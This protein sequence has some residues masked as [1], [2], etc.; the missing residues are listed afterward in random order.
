MCT[1]SSDNHARALDVLVA[2][3]HTKDASNAAK[4]SLLEIQSGAI[5]MAASAG[6]GQRAKLYKYICAV[7]ANATCVFIAIDLDLNSAHCLRSVPLD[8]RPHHLTSAVVELG[9]RACSK[10][11]KA[12]ARSSKVT[13]A[14][15][16]PDGALLQA[17]STNPAQWWAMAALPTSL[18]KSPA[19]SFQPQ[20]LPF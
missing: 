12:A 19:Q 3:W 20:A 6:K 16:A 14:K 2:T 10:A 7:R 5:G 15:I 9:H 1:A 18:G 11:L 4:R 13:M 17:M 8:T